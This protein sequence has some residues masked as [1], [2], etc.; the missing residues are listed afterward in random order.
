[1]KNAMRKLHTLLSFTQ[2][3]FHC[4]RETP[5]RTFHVVTAANNSGEPV[6]QFF[7]GFTGEMPK[8]CGSFVRMDDDDSLLAE[9]CA[10]W[11]EEEG[12]Y[13]V[14][15]WGHSNIE[16]SLYNHAAFMAGRYHWLVSPVSQRWEC[17][18]TLGNVSIGDF[19][20]IFVR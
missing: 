5:G 6:V 9:K 19:W 7:S 13:E 4:K 8:A 16:G 17:D 3:R 2:L 18:D 15:K 1:M 12:K 11:G 14:G 10:L 20:K